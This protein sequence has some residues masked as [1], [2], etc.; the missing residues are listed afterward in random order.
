MADLEGELQNLD[1]TI[2]GLEATVLN[3]D[4]VANAFRAE[5][6]DVTSAMQVAGRD[7]TGLGRSLG[8][9]LKGAME[10]LILDGA[11]LSDVMTNVG[12]SMASTVLSAALKPVSNSLAGAVTGLFGG[13][14]ANGGAFNSGQVQ[15]FANGGVVSSP[16]SF[17][18][19]GGRMGLMGEAGPEA[20]MPL[21]RGPDGKLGVRGGGGGGVNITMNVTSPDAASF[22]RS[23]SQIAAQIG[24]AIG[25]GR[26]NQ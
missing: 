4:A 14:F 16:T 12:R 15:A 26:R 9:N 21:A 3:A 20:I 24:R 2:A 6:E 13:L 5:I 10:D 8:T 17:G 7:A 23:R 1:V 22:S 11:K 19:R 18:M 25:Q